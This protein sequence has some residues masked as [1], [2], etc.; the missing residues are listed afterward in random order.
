MKAF[1][2]RGIFIKKIHEAEAGGVK[3]QNTILSPESM[4]Y[5]SL[6]FRL[7]LQWLFAANKK[8]IFQCGKHLVIF[9]VG[10]PVALSVNKAWLV[11]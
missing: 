6:M 4:P 9:M 10:L 11:L 8:F 5:D 2:Y 1:D 3:K 7:L